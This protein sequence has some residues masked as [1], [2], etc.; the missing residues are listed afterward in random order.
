[1]NEPPVFVHNAFGSQ[2]F[3]PPS[4]LHSFS[5]IHVSPLPVYPELQ[6]HVREFIPSWHDAF[7]SHGFVIHSSIFVQDTP[8]PSYPELHEHEYEPPVFVHVANWLHVAWPLEHSSLSVHDTSLTGSPEYPE[9]HWHTPELQ[10][11]FDPHSESLWHG[12]M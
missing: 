3:P 10:F 12:T 11:S 1:M 6:V 2:L 7:E 5:S 4:L 8:S 9:L